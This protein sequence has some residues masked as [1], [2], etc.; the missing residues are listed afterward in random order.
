MEDSGGQLDHKLRILILHA[1]RKFTKVSVCN[2][3]LLYTAE[4]SFRLLI[5]FL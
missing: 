5:S 4:V 3:E 1:T 2:V